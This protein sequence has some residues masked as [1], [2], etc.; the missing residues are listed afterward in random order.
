MRHPIA[1]T[2]VAMSVAA[3]SA[4]TTKGK[5]APRILIEP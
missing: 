1:P 2:I 4:T 5:R 3:A